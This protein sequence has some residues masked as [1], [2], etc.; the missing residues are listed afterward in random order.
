MKENNKKAKRMSSFIDSLITIEEMST[1]KEV[2][3]FP[4]EGKYYYYTNWSQKTGNAPNER[5]FTN[6]H[7]S[8]AGKYLRENENENASVFLN[9][10][11]EEVTVIHTEWLAFYEVTPETDLTK[12]TMAKK[13]EVLL[14]AQENREY[15]VTDYTEI[16]DLGKINQCC[17]STK[18]MINYVGKHTGM[19][20]EGWGKNMKQRSYFIKEGRQVIVEHTPTTAFF[21]YV[22]DPYNET[23]LACKMIGHLAHKCTNEKKRVAYFKEQ[24]PVKEITLGKELVVVRTPIEGKYYEAT[25]W[26][27]KDGHWSA[28]NHYTNETTKR[29]YVGKYLRHIQQGY[30]DSADHWA[31]FLRD[32]KEIEIEYDYWGKRA[33]YEVPEQQTQ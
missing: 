24:K 3:R 18:E 9:F 1:M 5:Y 8:H 25:T 6:N 4:E 11:R 13:K 10:K 27:R 7:M 20:S 23:C 14:S 17:Y 19:W 22:P 29:E 16:V 31:V 15:Y 12:L 28:E 32:D 30:G 33:F 21:R 2:V 26:D